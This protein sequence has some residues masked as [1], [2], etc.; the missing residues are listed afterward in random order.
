VISVI[1]T[2]RNSETDLALALAALVP[3]ATEGL[4]REVIVVDRGSAD[5]TAIVAVAAGC[6]F[7]A[8]GNAAG[9]ARRQAAARAKS[10][11]LLF[12]APRAM[13]EAGWQGEALAFIDAAVGSGNARRRAATLRFGR[14][15][16]GLRARLEEV[17]A[18]AR[19][20]LFAAPREEQGLLVSKALYRSLGGHRDIAA[21]A[22]VDLAR[23]V[24][25][26]RL[27]LLRARALVRHGGDDP[28][29]ARSLRNGLCFVML[30]LR[31]PPRLIDRL[32]A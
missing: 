23:R 27:W 19:T 18:T 4:V 9:E 1:I 16:P 6:E 31:L 14:M 10:D 22:D 11:W 25:R 17:M 12:L 30:L 2:T 5:G 15:G 32:A 20:R 13:V 28:S 29:L 26:R 8:A 7:I 21:L 3:A 24:G